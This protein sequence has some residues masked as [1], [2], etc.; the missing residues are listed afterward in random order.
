MDRTARQKIN[1]EMEALNN[2]RA[3]LDLADIYRNV[4]LDSRSQVHMEYS[5]GQ[6]IC[7]TATN[8]S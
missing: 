6:M 2:T 4:L 1:K 8:K 7:K 3:Q 5:L